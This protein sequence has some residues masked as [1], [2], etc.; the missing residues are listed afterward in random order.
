MKKLLPAILSLIFLANWL[1]AGAQIYTIT[2][3][4]KQLTEQT[5]DLTGAN[6]VYIHSGLCTNNPTD[7]ANQLT[8]WKHIVGNWGVDDGV[9]QMSNLGN[10]VYSISIDI[11]N[12]YGNVNLINTQAG[13]VVMPQG[14]T[15]YSLGLVFRNEDGTIKGADNTIDCADIYIFGLNTGTPSVQDH[16]GNPFP[17]VTLVTSTD[18]EQGLATENLKIWP[19]PARNKVNI[20]FRL[21]NQLENL[22]VAVYN[23][24]GQ[25]VQLLHEGN[26]RAGLFELGWDGRDEN[27]KQVRNGL[28]QLSINSG[29][30]MLSKK[31]VLM[32]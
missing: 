2:V 13:G 18:M 5:C 14:A 28:Y 6:K 16:F 21:H 31:I 24:L 3:D 27:G 30:R 22:E 23:N 11:N 12:Y 26:A 7:C 15:P 17:A 29:S 10:G 32:R 19:N 1:T 8:I 9:G 20:Q 4:S 25:R